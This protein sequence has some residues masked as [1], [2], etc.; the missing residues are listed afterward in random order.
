ME[1]KLFFHLKYIVNSVLQSIFTVFSPYIIYIRKYFFSVYLEETPVGPFLQCRGRSKSS[2][3]KI[4]SATYQFSVSL[5]FFFTYCTC[6]FSSLFVASNIDIIS[7]TLYIYK[8][9]IP[10][11][12]LTCNTCIRVQF[13]LAGT[14]AADGDRE[15]KGAVVAIAWKTGFA[16]NPLYNNHA[17]QHQYCSYTFDSI[18]HPAGPINTTVRFR[19]HHPANNTPWISY[20]YYMKR[21]YVIQPIVQGNDDFCNLKK[22]VDTCRLLYIQSSQ[23]TY[24]KRNTPSHYIKVL[25]SYFSLTH[26]TDI[27]RRHISFVGGSLRIMDRPI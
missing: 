19:P 15:R 12:Y 27:Y 4:E 23:H 21:L 7:F 8:A 14:I 25:V 1:Q 22:A 20:L 18:P 9:L 5:I 16:V 6:C 13:Y 11:I 3:S 17:L 26:I 2:K 10:C 24:I